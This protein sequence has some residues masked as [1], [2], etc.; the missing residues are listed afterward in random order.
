MDKLTDLVE[1][2]IEGVRSA[3]TAYVRDYEKEEA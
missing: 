2:H 3:V 1:A